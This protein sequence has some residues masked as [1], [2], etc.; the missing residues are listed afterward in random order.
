MKSLI[1]LKDN[2]SLDKAKLRDNDQ[3]ILEAY[4]IEE[5]NNDEINK[6]KN[7]IIEFPARNKEPSVE[8]KILAPASKIPKLERSNYI[9]T[10]SRIDL[11]RMTEEDLSEIKDFT[12]QNEHGKIVF[13]G[14]TDIKGLDLD[15]LV[16]IN[17]GE[18]IVYSDDNAKPSQGLG[19]NKPATIS[20]Y[21]CFPAK[22]SNEGRDHKFLKK[23]QRTAEK[24]NVKNKL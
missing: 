23:L 7:E 16:T 18:V 6:E 22:K 10:P 12:I 15:S 11:C 4:D 8:K 9:T 14:V 1:T 13:E 19:L 21:K 5:E 3:L 20:L 2:D 17:Q 24:Q